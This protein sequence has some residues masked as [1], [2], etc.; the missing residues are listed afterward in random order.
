MER[1]RVPVPLRRSGRR[2]RTTADS[3]PFVPKSSRRSTRPSTGAT[4]AAP[5][6]RCTRRSSTSCTSRASPRATPTSPRSCAAPTRAWRHPAAIEYLQRLGVTAVEL[7]PVHQFVHD[8]HL[9]ER[10]LRNYWGYNSIGFFAP[11]N[12]YAAARAARAPRC[13][14]SR[15]MVRALHAAGIEVILDVVYNHTAEG[16]H[17]GP[18][19]LLQGHRQRRLLPPGRRRPALLHGLHRHRQQ[20]QHAPPARAAADHGLAALLGAGDARRRLPLRPRRDAGARAARRRPA[21]PPSSTSSSRT[22]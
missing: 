15:R 16:N 8:A 4:T 9:V 20:P 12:E 7:M 17:L 11:H 2:R 19:A 3:A 10:G 13:A 22:R 1:G 5:T 18:D 21:R 6:R 14:S